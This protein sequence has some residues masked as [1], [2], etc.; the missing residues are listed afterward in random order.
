MYS[1]S[2]YGLGI[3]SEIQIPELK[4]LPD[5]RQPVPAGSGLNKISAGFQEP[6]KPGSK[7][8]EVLIHLGK[9]KPV[10]GFLKEGSPY[11]DVGNTQA[12]LSVPA[13]GDFIIFGGREII[14][15]PSPGA[16]FRLIRRFIIGT[17]M[18]ILLY[19]R[20]VLVLHASSVK[21]NRKAVAFLGE[22]GSGKSSIA[23]ALQTLGHEI[24]SDDITPLK[25][26]PDGIQAL[27]GYPQLKLSQEV[28]RV[29]GIQPEALYS[30]YEGETKRGYSVAHRFYDCPVRLDRLYVLTEGGQ[31]AI[32]PFTAQTAFIELLR[33]SYPT[34]LAQSGD[35]TH[36]ENCVNLAKKLPVFQLNRAQTIAS[37]F[38]LAKTIEKAC[39]L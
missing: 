25:F 38:E 10:Y 23:A 16:D 36:F 26:G 14:V 20:G 1:Y 2:A 5:N 13:V 33:H 11:L 12:A 22:S 18:A 32:V 30:L 21:I 8:C 6:G 19:Q 7:A 39:D 29:L 3:D 34:R 15:Y 37:L 24:L 4:P 9:S 28:A 35:V 31:P 17:V 27:P